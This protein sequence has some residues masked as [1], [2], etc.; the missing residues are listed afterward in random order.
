M[1]TLIAQLAPLWQV[2]GALMH[3]IC[4]SIC[5]SSSHDILLDWFLDPDCLDSLIKSRLRGN[6]FSWRYYFNNSGPHSILVN[7]AHLFIYQY[8]DLDYLTRKRGHQAAQGCNS[9][10]V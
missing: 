3:D 1:F 7:C 2:V 10:N 9:H 6:P 4:L 8:V 5:T